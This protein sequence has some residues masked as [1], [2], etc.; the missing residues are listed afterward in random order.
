MNAEPAQQGLGQ[1][2]R[3]ILVRTFFH[4]NQCN[5][6]FRE[7]IRDQLEEARAGDKQVFLRLAGVVSGGPRNLSSRKGFSRT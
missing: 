3:D 5:T 7:T 1:T 6:E 2:E 4:I